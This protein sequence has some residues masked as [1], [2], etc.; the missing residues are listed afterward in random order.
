MQTKAFAE[1]DDNM[2]GTEKHDEMLLWL[3]DEHNIAVLFNIKDFTIEAQSIIKTDDDVLVG[4]HDIVIKS[5]GCVGQKPNTKRIFKMYIEVKPFIKSF[6]Q[7]MKQ[8]NTYKLYTPHDGNFCLFTLDMRYEEAF[9]SQG[10][11]VLTMPLE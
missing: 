1:L 2:I 4:F 5:T 10:I 9:E 8:I 3:L 6:T 11:T 7:T